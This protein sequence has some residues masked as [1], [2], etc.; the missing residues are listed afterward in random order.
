[1]GEKLIV[2]PISK[3]LK[4]NVKP[5]N[6]D[7]DSFP[8][9][10]NAYQWRGQIKRKRGTTFLTR[11]RRTLPEMSIGNTAASPWTF[12]LFSF[13]S[14]SI[15]LSEPNA[16]LIPGSIHITIASTPIIEFMDNGNGTLSGFKIGTIT[17]AS[18]ANPAQITSAGH[19]LITGDIVTITG[20]VGMTQL[21]GN[22]YTITVTGVNTFTLN[23][24][25][26]T[27]FTA[28]VSGGTWTSPSAANFGVINYLTSVVTLTGTFAPG[29][30]ATACISYYPCLPV[31]GFRDL[32]VNSSQ[33]PANLSFDTKYS[34]N[35]LDAFP[36]T[37]Y[38]VSYY[39]NP[40]ADGVNLPG[41]IPK[42]VWTPLTWNGQNYQQFYTLNYQGALWATNGIEVP[43]DPTNVGMQYKPIV[44]VTIIAGGPPATAT[45]QI[46][47]HGLVVGDFV[48][49]NEVLTTT[50]INFQTGYV[51]TVTDA[52]NV[53][54]EFPFAT[55]ATNGTG[56]IAQYLTST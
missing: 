1:M 37:A 6:I 9:L 22:T 30:A 21:N 42:T 24:I 43:F 7:N 47:T 54:V 52:N 56:G 49:V 17:G 53:I 19:T 13:I 14:P 3:G 23:G 31:M 27:G 35:V 36:Y 41:Y 15:T 44:T 26:S 32:S 45:L 55:I 8:V 29:V 11:L 20:I 48:F 33:F 2:G 40:A 5:F 16:S 50:G 46:I 4:S 39:K 38:D 12:N 51:I 25:D 28:Y 18:Q 34:Y 10:I